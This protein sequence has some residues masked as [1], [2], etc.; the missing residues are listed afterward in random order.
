MTGKLGVCQLKQIYV[1]KDVIKS[2]GRGFL[3]AT[4]IGKWKKKEPKEN[5]QLFDSPPTLYLLYLYPTAGNLSGGPVSLF[6]HLMAGIP[7]M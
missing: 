2:R 5:P 6:S 1:S 7:R 3:P 4:F